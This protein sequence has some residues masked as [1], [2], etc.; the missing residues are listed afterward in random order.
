MYI[1]NHRIYAYISYRPKIPTRHHPGIPGP[2]SCSR[3]VRAGASPAREAARPA[4]GAQ[5]QCFRGNVAAISGTQRNWDI[6][7]YYIITHYIYIYVPH[8]YTYTYIII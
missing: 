8:V 6:S 2:A 5:R 7:T 4:R 1:C 3:A